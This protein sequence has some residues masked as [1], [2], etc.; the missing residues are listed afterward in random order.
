MPFDCNGTCGRQDLLDHEMSSM[1]PVPGG[2]T[3]RLCNR[4]DTSNRVP[5]R[6]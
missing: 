5:P 4:C 2:G 6:P 1:T 3:I